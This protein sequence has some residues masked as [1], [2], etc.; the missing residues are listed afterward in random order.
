MDEKGQTHNQ[1]E[2]KPATQNGNKVEQNQSRN[3]IPTLQKWAMEMKEFQ[4]NQEVA[5]FFFFKPKTNKQSC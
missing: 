2:E 3:H 1:R 5:V 4:Q